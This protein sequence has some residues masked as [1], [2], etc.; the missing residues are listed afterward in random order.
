MIK[1]LKKKKML[2]SE[3]DNQ[4]RYHICFTN[5]Y[6]MRGIIPQ[7]AKEGFIPTKDE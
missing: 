2:R 4:R 3:K 6:L 7:L 1:N 5:N